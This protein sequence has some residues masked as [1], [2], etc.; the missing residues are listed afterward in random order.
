[1]VTTVTIFEREVWSEESRVEDKTKCI[2]KPLVFAKGVMAQIMT[3]TPYSHETTTL[4]KP[5]NRPCYVIEGFMEKR[6]VI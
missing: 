2:I 5:I 1:M 4:A 6:D 3:N